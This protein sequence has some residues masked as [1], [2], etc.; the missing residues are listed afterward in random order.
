MS[1]LTS[2][3]QPD[4]LWVEKTLIEKRLPSDWIA[5]GAIYEILLVTGANTSLRNIADAKLPELQELGFNAVYVMGAFEMETDPA[6]DIKGSAFCLRNHRK[7]NKQ[8]GA[9]GDLDNLFYEAHQRGM[10][11]GVDLVLNHVSRKNPLARRAGFCLR[12]D[13]GRLQTAACTTIIDGRSEELFFS[14]VVQLDLSNP[15]VREELKQIVLSIVRRAPIGCKLFFRVD[16]AAQMMNR[17]LERRWGFQM[18]EQEWMAE[19]IAVARAINPNVAFVA[20]VN[21]EATAE[22]L[23]AIGYNVFPSKGNEQRGLAKGWY[24]AHVSQDPQQI[25]FAIAS[26]VYA[27]DDPRASGMATVGGHDEAFFMRAMGAW[28]PGAMALTLM[29]RPL[30]WLGSTEWGQDY[31]GDRGALPD[32]EENKAIPFGVENDFSIKDPHLLATWKRICRLAKRVMAEMGNNVSYYELLNSQGNNWV[33]YA[34]KPKYANAPVY[35]VVGNPTNQAVSF[36]SFGPIEPKT[37]WLFNAH[38]GQREKLV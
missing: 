13:S 36:H 7:V 4:Q 23:R 8:W 28:G 25:N 24:D 9:E 1:R 31:Q 2:E 18:P 11:I 35:Y 10:G 33:G 22:E 37:V 38:S 19:I 12:D 29:M 17:Q 20:E 26:L 3:K 21:G 15:A 34:I 14:D 32:L 5:A 6:A 16:M 30:L 27:Q